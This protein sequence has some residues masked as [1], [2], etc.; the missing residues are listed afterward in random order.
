MTVN[1]YVP[2]KVAKLLADPEVGPWVTRLYDK[3]DLWEEAEAE[4]NEL[5]DRAER[6]EALIHR[7]LTENRIRHDHAY[8]MEIGD[9]HCAGCDLEAELLKNQGYTI[10]EDGSRTIAGVRGGHP[11]IIPKED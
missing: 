2:M 8:P 3:I 5:L 1:R 9:H 10:N 4:C 6:A 11:R 7:V